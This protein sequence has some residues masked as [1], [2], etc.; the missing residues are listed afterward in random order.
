[1]ALIKPTQVNIF[2][3]FCFLLFFPLTYAATLPICTP[4]FLSLLFRFTL[5]HPLS[6]SLSL[7]LPLSLSL[8]ALP[9][10]LSLPSLSL[11]Q[12]ISLSL[13]HHLSHSGHRRPPSLTLSLTSAQGFQPPKKK[14]GFALPLSLRRRLS[15]SLHAFRSQDRRKTAVSTNSNNRKNFRDFLQ[16]STLVRNQISYDEIFVFCL[17]YP[18]F[19]E[20]FVRKSKFYSVLDNH[21]VHFC[22][23]NWM[24]F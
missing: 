21:Y 20:M 10:S 24:H 18:C 14:A 22:R 4:P 7:S 12:T 2:F 15:L 3:S 13:S 5:P 17:F 1:V 19:D 11:S 6:F 16:L 23:Y 9:F 8:S